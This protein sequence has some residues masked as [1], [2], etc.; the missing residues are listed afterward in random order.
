MR[1]GLN[2]AIFEDHNKWEHLFSKHGKTRWPN[3]A[4]EIEGQNFGWGDLFTFEFTWTRKC[5]HAGV[6]LKLG[7]FGYQ[8]EGRFYDSRHWDEDTND[9]KVYDEAYFKHS[10]TPAPVSV[11]S[12]AEKA[13]AVEEFLMSDQGKRLIDK[14]VAE[15][16]EE[17]KRAKLAKAAR[18]EAYRRANLGEPEA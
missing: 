12:Q 9:Y 3:K 13:E 8:V 10:Y 15:K 18:G 16:V 2:L 7:L 4:W 1:I 17:Q 6:S 11:L 14:K 5:D